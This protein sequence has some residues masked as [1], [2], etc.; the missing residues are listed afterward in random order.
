MHSEHLQNVQIGWVFFGWFVA[1]S[2]ASSLALLLIGSGLMPRG[3]VAADLTV[4]GAVFVG[5]F[6]GGFSTCYRTAAAPILHG[7]AIALF[8]FVAWFVLNLALGGVT[9][10]IEAWEQV[11]FRGATIALLIQGVA[12]IAG[13][14]LG[15]RYAPVRVP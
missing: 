5:W 15:Y 13:S 7:S 10:G 1:F 11:S 3:A 2:A 8:T 4:A 12:A 9:T 14:W 6:L